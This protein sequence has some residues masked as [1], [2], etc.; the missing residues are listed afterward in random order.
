MKKTITVP[1]KGTQETLVI[2]GQKAVDEYEQKTIFP[3]IIGMDS[4]DFMD[5]RDQCHAIARGKE[6]SYIRSEIPSAENRGEIMQS[7]KGATA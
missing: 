4:P 1:Q 6:I 2:V 7:C 5:S 3:G